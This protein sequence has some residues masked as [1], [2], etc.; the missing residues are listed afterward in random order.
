MEG[1][2]SFDM[3]REAPNVPGVSWT[4]EK[5]FAK[6]LAIRGVQ[7]SFSNTPSPSLNQKEWDILWLSV[8]W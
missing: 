1:G 5:D 3:F 4:S 8:C 6:D 7:G 2:N